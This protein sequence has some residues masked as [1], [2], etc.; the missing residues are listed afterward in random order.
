MKK[1]KGR[2]SSR[3]SF[4]QVI[5]RSEM[6]FTTTTYLPA[7]SFNIG[8]HTTTQV[9]PPH[10][11]LQHA[12]LSNRYQP[13]GRTRTT[14]TRS[15]ARNLRRGDA[16]LQKNENR[17]RITCI[18]RKKKDLQKGRKSRGNTREKSK[19]LFST[20]MGND[21]GR[22]RNVIIRV[23]ADLN[24]DR[25]VTTLGLL[26]NVRITA[27]HGQVLTTYGRAVVTPIIRL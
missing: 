6:T 4:N 23:M 8:T 25:I 18:T 5:R 3:I 9:Q 19:N 24:I 7:L 16:H 14:L 21:N 10:S 13:P 26:M 20:T 15:G 11:Y 17:N 1:N 12:P 22:K 27:A 2:Y